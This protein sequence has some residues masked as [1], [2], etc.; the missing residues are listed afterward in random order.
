MSIIEKLALMDEYRLLYENE[1]REVSET[2]KIR[3]LAFLKSAKEVGLKTLPYE[4]GF[5]ICVPYPNPKELMHA[6]HEDGVYVICTRTCLRIALCAIN[7]EEAERL[8]YL[9]KNRIEKMG[10]SK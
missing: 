6:L 2:L 4:R 9:I 7:K 1:I 3:C 8:P 5:F 10:I